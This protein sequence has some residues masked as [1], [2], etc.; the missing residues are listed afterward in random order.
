MALT[1][2]V[3]IVKYMVNGGTLLSDKTTTYSLE[4]GQIAGPIVERDTSGVFTPGTYKVTPFYAITRAVYPKSGSDSRSWEFSTPLYRYVVTMSGDL[5]MCGQPRT[6]AAPAFL[7]ATDPTCVSLQQEALL[8]AYGKVGQLA[9]LAGLVELAELR[10]SIEML[11]QTMRLAL[12]PSDLWTTLRYALHEEHMWARLGPK[13]L[14]QASNRYLECRYG[15][16]PLIRSVMGAVELVK[17]G[18][19]RLDDTTRIYTARAKVDAVYH[20]SVKP[21]PYSYGLNPHVEVGY[22]V[23]NSVRALACVHYNVIVPP[24]VSELLGFSPKLIPE[25]VWAVS[26]LSFV[27]D[28]F[29]SIGPWLAAIRANADFSFAIL[30]NTVSTTVTSEGVGRTKLIATGAPHD[31]FEAYVAGKEVKRLTNRPIPNPVIRA[32][33]VID[34]L[35]QLDLLIFAW[36]KLPRRFRK[37]LQRNYAA[38]LTRPINYT[39]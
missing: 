25:A 13:V 37:D 15:W 23:D 21:K 31:T 35:K 28:W 1:L 18:L 10:E 16:L 29:L 2:Q 6:Q 22:D 33:Q 7:S 39:E 38:L 14:S 4:S 8:K 20:R 9:Q 5:G 34:W 12:N 27:W 19:R 30:G 26:K 32:G 17:E 24:T 36:Q 3:R 11:F